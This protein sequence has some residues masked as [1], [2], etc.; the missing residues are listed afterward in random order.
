MGADQ[1]Q[2]AVDL[3]A[4]PV[5]VAATDQVLVQPHPFGIQRGAILVAQVRAAE[6]ELAADVGADQAQLTVGLEALPT[7]VAAAEE[8]LVDLHAVCAEGRVVRAAQAR[9]AQIEL[10]ADVRA[11]QAHPAI[12]AKPAA[13]HRDVNFKTKTIERRTAAGEPGRAQREHATDLRS[14]EHELGG[15]RDSI[16]R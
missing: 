14:G 5:V 1:A 8:V 16:Q 2:R 7:A 6:V 11:D 9:A 13:L 15:L 3:E 10:P 12:R 4:L